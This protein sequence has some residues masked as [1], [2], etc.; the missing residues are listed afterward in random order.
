MR[1]FVLL[2]ALLAAVPLRAEDA[3]PPLAAT[4]AAGDAV[5]LHASGR[6]EYVDRVKAQEAARLAARQPDRL[7]RADAQG[8]WFGLGREIA[9]GDADYNRGSL[10]PKLR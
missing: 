6:W 10:N 4:T 1:R 3:P 8:G 2:A 5:L 9:P 7:R